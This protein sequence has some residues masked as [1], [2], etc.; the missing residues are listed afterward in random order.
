MLGFADGTIVPT[1]PVPDINDE[2]QI[3]Y[4]GYVSTG[5]TAAAGLFV[6]TAGMSRWYVRSGDAAPGG[7]VYADFG[8]P[9]LNDAGEIAFY[10]DYNLSPGHLREAGSPARPAT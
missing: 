6:S 5:N 4:R 10:S 1:G 3:A 8:A 2:G 9:I 7:G